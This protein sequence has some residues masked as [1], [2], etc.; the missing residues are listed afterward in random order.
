VIKIYDERGEKVATI[1]GSASLSNAATFSM[2]LSN[3]VPNPNGP[4]GTISVY[5]D[6]QLVGVWNATD[7]AGNLV[8]NG[9]YHFVLQEHTNNGGVV[10]L[11]RDAFIPTYHGES[12][13]LLALPNVGHPGDI[14]KLTASFAGIPA[15]SQSKIKIYATSGE[16]VQNLPISGGVASW[17]LKNAN[18]Q[19]VASGVYV[20]VLDRIDPSSGQKLSKITKILV[21]H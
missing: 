12:V 4:G 5:L 6:G 1:C 21:T 10:Q 2:N 20:V 16:L 3:F 13:S 7:D 19:I 11:E 17:D 15:D 9:Y 18:G 14:L 8:P